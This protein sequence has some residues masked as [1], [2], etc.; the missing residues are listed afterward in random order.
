MAPSHAISTRRPTEREQ[1]LIA[2]QA[3]EP[4]ASYGCILVAFGWVPLVLIVLLIAAIAGW[5]PPAPWY[6][7]IVLVGGLAL[8]LWLLV[9]M[10]VQFRKYELKQREKARRDQSRM[11]VEVIEVRDPVAVEV[12]PNSAADPAIALDIGA[13]KI[14]F[15]QGQWLREGATYGTPR[16]ADDPDESYFN[17]SPPPHAFPS[18][19]FT[20][21]RLSDS[22]RVLG[23]AV[24]GAYVPVR[25][26]VD[27]LQPEHEMPE[28]ELISGT[29]DRLAEAFATA[30][31]ARSNKED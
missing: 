7:W 25:G 30:A 22:G 11:M 15:L 13:R 12:V 17:G 4:T 10:L 19:R 28:S 3:G 5:V 9:W 18:T 21:A 24:A 14:L 20:L 23:V 26:P 27:V 2:A 1:R 16:Q 31:D 8:T 29:L 6:A